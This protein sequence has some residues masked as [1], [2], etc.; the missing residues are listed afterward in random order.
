MSG[1]PKST[2]L[3]VRLNLSKPDVKDEYDRLNLLH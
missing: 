3:R 1:K 2:T